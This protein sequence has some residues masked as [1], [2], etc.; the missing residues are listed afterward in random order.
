MPTNSLPNMEP[1]SR[2]KQAVLFYK[3][4]YEKFHVAPSVREMAAYL[5]VYPNAAHRILKQ[6]E[7]KGLIE[8]RP[9]T[10]MRMKLSEKGKKVGP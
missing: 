3:K 4:H 2:E 10:V 9:V 1:T 5:G 7:K 6:M 8:M